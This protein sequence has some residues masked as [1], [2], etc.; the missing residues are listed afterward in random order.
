M[1]GIV[2]Y[3][4]GNLLSVQSAVEMAGAE[5]RICARPEEL[6][7]VE[8]IILPGVGAFRDCVENLRR[9]GFVEALEEQVIQGGKPIFG[10]CLGMQAMARTSEEGGLY[11]GLGW[12]EADVVRLQPDD[13]TLRVP[14]IGWNDV[15]YRRDSPLF[16]GEPAVVD[17][18]FVHSYYMKCD[19]PEDVEG[20]CDYGGP[21]TAAVRKG[22]I[23]A[24][25][26]HPEKSQ[27]HGLK[28]LE[29]FLAWKP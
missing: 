7:E 5:P 19:R 17:F 1:V 3:G 25:Q 15:D 6:A 4:M 22:N 21:V 29:N 14:Q 13:L 20:T 10:I 27:D 11:R 2:D 12:F 26:F 28:L 24:T 8:R 18:Y 23:F 9:G 16:A